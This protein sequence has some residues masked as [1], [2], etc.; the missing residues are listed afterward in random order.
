MRARS[1]DGA[2]PLVS[3][4]VV[5]FRRQDLLTSCLQ[6]VRTAL[7]ELNGPAEA[8]VVDNGAGG[9][10]DEIV[11]RQ[12]PDMRLLSIGENV[13]FA[14]AV[15]RGVRV[16]RAPWVAVLNDD[17]TVDPDALAALLQAGGTDPSVGAVA[18]QLRF[19]DRPGMI[20]SAG[21]ELDRLG[22]AS[23]RLLGAS[24]AESEHEPIEVFGASGGAA[25]YR[26]SMLEE[27]GGF[28]ESFFAYLE[29]V[30]LAWRARMRGWRAL[31]APRAV[32]YH[33]HSATLGHGSAP[34]LF[35]VG[36]N[37][38]RLLAKNATTKTLLRHG[39][40]IVVYEL[41]YVLFAAI[42]F[43]TLAPLRGRLVGLREWQ[44]Y[45][46]SGAADRRHL[47]LV[48]AAGASRALRRH[49]VWKD[50]SADLDSTRD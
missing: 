47:Q 21:I 16:T 5:T 50:A 27:L 13:G 9:E 1:N 12:F 10:S 35:L 4:V 6:S 30:D 17:L 28:D 29:D 20:N 23:D 11:R 36:R 18:A 25:L 15:M 38:V 48:P 2:E 3:V 31:Y 14:A 26:R 49:R 39:S 37:R 44:R 43:R 42:R 33:H 41:A 32:A 46:Q 8:V 45:R 40:G 22:V 7:E 19:A 34:K 24:V